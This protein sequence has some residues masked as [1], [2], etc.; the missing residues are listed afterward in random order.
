ME[1]RVRGVIDGGVVWGTQP[2]GWKGL[3]SDKNGRRWFN[4]CLSL[5]VASSAAT[6]SEV[7]ESVAGTWNASML[8]RR[9]CMSLL[10]FS[11]RGIKHWIPKYAYKVPWQ[12]R[13]ELVLCPIFAPF[14][15]TSVRAKVSNTLSYVDASLTRG[16]ITKAQMPAHTAKE[17]QYWADVKGERTFLPSAVEAMYNGYESKGREVQLT[18]VEQRF[19]HLT[20]ALEHKSH[21]DFR[22]RKKAHV[23]LSDNS[24]ASTHIKNLAN[25]RSNWPMRFIVGTYSKCTRGCRNR[26]RSSSFRL[27]A[28]SRSSSPYLI[29][30]D[31][32]VAY[33]Y[34]YA[35]DNPGDDGTRERAVR[36]GGQI[37]PHMHD[38]LEN[39]LRLF[40]EDAIKQRF[41]RG[42]PR[43]EAA[44]NLL[45]AYSSPQGSADFLQNA[46]KKPLT[47]ASNC[48]NPKVNSSVT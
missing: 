16:R 19:R 37:L 34:I 1:K 41:T 42:I 35:E 44:Q 46:Q 11:D 3:V 45:T 4:S 32:Y 2:M 12:L 18:H 47:L 13:G 6:C 15:R 43:G 30:A 29:G 10:D 22:F 14:M 8:Y 5:W 23:N 20:F 24:V 33:H 9:P 25:D 48:T 38:M 28:F 40:S 26:G 36:P 39:R 7:I 27:N 31:I 17:L 21:I